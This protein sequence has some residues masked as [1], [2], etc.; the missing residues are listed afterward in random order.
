MDLAVGVAGHH[1][2][3]GADPRAQEIPGLRHLGVV[4]DIDPAPRE[5]PL[6]FEV[7]D[8]RVLEDFPVDPVVGHQPGQIAVLRHV[9]L[10]MSARRDSAVSPG[11]VQP[12]PSSR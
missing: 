3:L 4:A 2:G 11:T 12:P 5:N 1:D 6:H 9:A 10:P 8:R 7:E